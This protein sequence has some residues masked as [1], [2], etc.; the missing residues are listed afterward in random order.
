M[1]IIADNVCQHLF[2]EVGDVGL[3][4]ADTSYYKHDTTHS[5]L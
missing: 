2:A 4:G 5:V 3:K 1:L